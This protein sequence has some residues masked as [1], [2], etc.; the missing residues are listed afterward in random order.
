MQICAVQRISAFFELFVA[1]SDRGRSKLREILLRLKRC[2]CFL[3]FHTPTLHFRMV[4]LEFRAIHTGGEI[5]AKHGSEGK[6]SEQQKRFS[7]FLSFP[8]L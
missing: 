8:S 5:E 6:D 2:S 3:E 7:H 1:H 4:S